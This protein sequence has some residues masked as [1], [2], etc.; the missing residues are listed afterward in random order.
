MK[1]IFSVVFASLLAALLF[2]QCKK[3]DPN[4]IFNASFYTTKATGSLSLYIDDIYRGELPYFSK[5]PTCG[6]QNGDGQSPLTM[7]LKSGEYRIV[8]KNSQDRVTSSGTI[9]ISV[10]TTSASGGIGG[11]SIS[12]NGGC[13]VIGLFE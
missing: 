13:V 11:Q 2:T 8:G 10:S 1:R 6:A 4:A 9:A 12:N 3:D 7:Q 5:E